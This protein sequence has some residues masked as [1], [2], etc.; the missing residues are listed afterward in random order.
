MW[1]SREELLPGEGIIM[2]SDM[3]EELADFE[4]RAEK[5]GRRL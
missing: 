5:L 3:R 1:G 4:L 2:I